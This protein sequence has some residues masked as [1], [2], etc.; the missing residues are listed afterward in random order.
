MPL[1]GDV[2]TTDC[3]PITDLESFK[4]VFP[5]MLTDAERKERFAKQKADILTFLRD[6]IGYLSEILPLLH[7]DD[8][9]T[10]LTDF[11][12]DRQELF[13]ITRSPDFNGKNPNF[14]F[15]F[16]A[17]IFPRLTSQAQ[18]QAL[19]NYCHNTMKIEI[20]ILCEA[21][22]PAACLSDIRVTTLE[23]FHEHINHQD[24]LVAVLACLT[25]AELKKMSETMPNLDTARKRI[26]ETPMAAPPSTPESARTPDELS[27]TS[28]Q[29]SLDNHT[30][31]DGADT[32]TSQG[33][34]SEIEI[35]V[36][37]FLKIYSALRAMLSF[38]F[39][40]TDTWTHIH[41]TE[42]VEQSRIVI[43]QHAIRKPNSRTAIAL[44]LAK[45]PTPTGTL[46]QAQLVANVITEG[47]KQDP[48]VYAELNDSYFFRQ[49][50]VEA[51]CRALADSTPNLLSS[52]DGEI[53]QK[54]N[55][56]L[57]P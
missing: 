22:R 46:E 49:R 15:K 57:F 29:T 16:L 19:Y 55:A 35:N 54:V 17:K 39:L 18:T 27:R 34:S 38:Q 7:P 8:Y 41:P 25:P 53:V 56:I 36:P 26:Q 31:N 48:L 23:C 13:K 10:L 9:N 21:L 45:I 6:N 52:L 5:P 47:F 28:S 43:Q 51:H 37:L 2:P 20:S 4:A 30:N 12:R 11:T 24:D 42:E 1:P 14:P 50:S 3:K 40:R 44:A 32:P 33:G